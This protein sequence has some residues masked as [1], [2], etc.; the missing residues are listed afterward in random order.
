MSDGNAD[1]IKRLLHDAGTSRTTFVSFL[2]KVVAVVRY[3]NDTIFSGVRWLDQA[4]FKLVVPLSFGYYTSAQTPITLCFPVLYQLLWWVLQCCV[5]ANMSL[6]GKDGMYDPLQCKFGALHWRHTQQAITDFLIRVFFFRGFTE[7]LPSDT[8]SFRQASPTALQVA[9]MPPEEHVK[10]VAE[11]RFVN[12]PLED[13]VLHVAWPSC[14]AALD[15]SLQS[16]LQADLLNS[17]PLAEKV[18]AD[19]RR[20]RTEGGL[21]KYFLNGE[22]NLS[23][24]GQLLSGGDLSDDFMLWTETC[25][26]FL[27]ASRYAWAKRLAFASDRIFLSPNHGDDPTSWDDVPSRH[28]IG[29][30]FLLERTKDCEAY[31]FVPANGQDPNFAPQGPVEGDV[32]CRRGYRV[33]HLQGLQDPD[34]YVFTKQAA[35]RAGLRVAR[36]Y[37]LINPAVSRS[38]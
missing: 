35:M 16:V 1:L 32:A 27:W 25:D 13:G 14:A 22:A 17:G 24:A 33:A 37:R 2:A 10:S 3:M 38:T 36:I 23:A 6:G 29:Y 21:P 18:N 15:T 11:L 9:E 12:P 34:A 7:P 8:A 26:A 5:L 19:L 4:L 20:C 28:V 31:N 30:V